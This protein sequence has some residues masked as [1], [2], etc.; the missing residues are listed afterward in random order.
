MLRPKWTTKC[1]SK[2]YQRCF[3]CMKNYHIKCWRSS[4]AA[5]TV[6]LYLLVRE[7]VFRRAENHKE[8]HDNIFL[9]NMTH[10]EILRKE[11]VLF[12]LDPCAWTDCG[13]GMALHY[14][15]IN[16]KRDLSQLFLFYWCLVHE[17]AQ[18]SQISCTFQNRFLRRLGISRFLY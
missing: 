7:H 18:I 8:N 13:I 3:K 16:V 6:Q 2:L 1:I 9:Y 15:I 14:R 11:D 17:H 5:S 4:G 10:R 12:F